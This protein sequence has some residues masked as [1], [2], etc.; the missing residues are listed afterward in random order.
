MSPRATTRASNRH[1][2]PEAKSSTQ[3]RQAHSK[4]IS[5]FVMSACSRR[6]ESQ[7]FVVP[8][9][10]RRSAP[11]FRRAHLFQAKCLAPHSAHEGAPSREAHQGPPERQPTHL[12]QG[13]RFRHARTVSIHALAHSSRATGHDEIV[14]T[15]AADPLNQSRYAHAAWRRR[16]CRALPRRSANHTKSSRSA[17]RARAAAAST[18]PKPRSSL[19]VHPAK[20][21]R[22]HACPQP[23]LKRAC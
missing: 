19:P 12:N 18:S 14:R 23:N 15:R 13:G 16:T 21:A 6:S 11:P 9:C 1:S 8:T 4:R 2:S 17:R 5:I 3:N 10:S 22:P 7:L 20:R